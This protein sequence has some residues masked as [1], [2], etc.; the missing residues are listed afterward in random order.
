MRFV[1]Y[2]DETL[3]PITVLNLPFTDRDM[4]QRMRICGQRLRVPVM[5]LLSAASFRMEENPPICEDLKVV[6][7]EFEL[8]VR[9]SPR[10][11]RQESWTCFTQATELAML[12]QPDWLPGQRNAVNYLMEQ[13]DALTRML[14]RAL[15]R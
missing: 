9:N 12:L 5:P 2:D 7:L 6:D 11:G 3:E 1:V 15:T 10:H 13:N 8:F 14:M 4:N